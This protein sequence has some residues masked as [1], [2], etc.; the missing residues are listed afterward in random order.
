MREYPVWMQS[1]GGETCLA[2][3][4]PFLISFKS[5]GWVIVGEDHVPDATEMIEPDHIPDASEMVKRKGWPKG[6]KRKP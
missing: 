3:S 5:D 4:E 1:P 6:K 2:P